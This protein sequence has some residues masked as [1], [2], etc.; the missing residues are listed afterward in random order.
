MVSDKVGVISLIIFAKFIKDISINVTVLY[1]IF[2][3][4]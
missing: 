4:D 1:G 3:I 2:S